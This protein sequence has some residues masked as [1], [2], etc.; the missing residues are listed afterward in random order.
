MNPQ[1]IQELNPSVVMD[2]EMDILARDRIMVQRGDRNQL[3]RKKE[4][5]MCLG[6]YP[7]LIRCFYN[8][9]W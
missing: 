2:L 5:Y 3:K 8:D 7:D 1:T 6:T 4:K 9:F